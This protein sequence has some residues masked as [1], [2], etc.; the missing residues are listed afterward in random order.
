MDEELKS[1]DPGLATRNSKLET[2]LHTIRLRHPW[3]CETNSD[4][5]VWSRKFNWP[6]E[7]DES[8]R[9]RLVAEGLPT[10]A[11]WTLNGQP[12]TPNSP[13]THDITDLIAIHNRL[14]ITIAAPEGDPPERFPY[15]VRLEIVAAC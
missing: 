1:R 13:T 3:Q 4:V 6:A 10:S 12:I 2:P 11:Q 15:E 7:P 8:E 14:L 5:I 9:V